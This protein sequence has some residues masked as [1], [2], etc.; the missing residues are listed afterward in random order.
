LSK[1]D[2]LSSGEMGFFEMGVKLT[3]C[4][5]EVDDVSDCTRYGLLKN[6]G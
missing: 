5:G 4:E 6:A 1:V 3:I 2:F